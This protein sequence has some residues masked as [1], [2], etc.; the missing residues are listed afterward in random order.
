MIYS[1]DDA[2]R[3][4]QEY[5]EALH[6]R[7]AEIEKLSSGFHHIEI[8]AFHD[9]HLG[10]RNRQ[11]H[12]FSPSAFIP[13]ESHYKN[14]YNAIHR[15]LSFLDDQYGD[16]PLPGN[17]S[18]T[19][20]EHNIHLADV[21]IQALQEKRL[22]YHAFSVGVAAL[23]HN[24]GLGLGSQYCEQFKGKSSIG[25]VGQASI[26]ILEQMAEFCHLYQ[27]EDIQE[28]IKFFHIYV[29]TSI[30]SPKLHVER[31]NNAWRHAKLLA[32][33]E[34]RVRREEIFN[35]TAKPEGFWSIDNITKTRMSEK[36]AEVAQQAEH[37]R[38][39]L[40][41]KDHRDPYLAEIAGLRNKA[42]RL[43][44]VKQ[45]AKIKGKVIAN[46]KKYIT[47]LESGS[48]KAIIAARIKLEVVESKL[49]DFMDS[50]PHDTEEVTTEN[51]SLG[52][53]KTE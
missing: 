10:L 33:A 25:G 5:E 9:R 49:R 1:D 34:H 27:M 50:N 37:E 16:T 26:A 24:I 7:V 20:R 22:S 4:K 6:R 12:G 15:L 32:A 13:I 11:D 30:N 51:G 53:E 31:E 38:Q 48:E 39:Q 35:S 46:Q 52:T 23:G 42:K 45:E 14:E 40:E 18:T 17:T 3:I 41:I 19:L 29:D 28:T 36:A 43:P 8:K 2:L 44:R 47:A 21:V